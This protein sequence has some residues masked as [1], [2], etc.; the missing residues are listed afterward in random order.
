MLSGTQPKA[1]SAD[2]HKKKD[3]DVMKNMF[4]HKSLLLFLTI[5]VGL[6]LRTE[7]TR[8]KDLNNF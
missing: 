3:E 5:S 6:S 1:S 8:S 2:H 4:M 7:I